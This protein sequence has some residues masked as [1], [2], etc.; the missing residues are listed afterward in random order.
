MAFVEPRSISRWLV[1][2]A[3][4]AACCVVGWWLLFS[5]SN[6]HGNNKSSEQRGADN[7]QG[8]R[9]PEITEETH[10][11]LSTQE[12][13][14]PE[15]E[16][17]TLAVRLAIKEARF[18]M[19]EFE[20]RNSS[21]VEKLKFANGES[22][23]ISI[24]AP[25]QE[26]LNEVYSEF[27]QLQSKFQDTPGDAKILRMTLDELIREYTH[28]PK[29]YKVISLASTNGGKNASFTSIFT[30]KIE[31][32]LP[33]KDGMIHDRADGSLK[34]DWGWKAKNS[35][36]SKR[37]NHLLGIDEKTGTVTTAISD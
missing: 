21:V 20:K 34:I 33:D 28:F 18:K 24:A 2:S 26:Q 19:G 16:I 14:F 13:S 35:L 22:V 8:S 5:S 11:N 7:L 6:Q 3:I 10:A 15:I 4:V 37:Y 17:G 30:D 12:I 9:R 29:A 32:T 23:Y 31:D 1:V 25:T 27:S 36:S